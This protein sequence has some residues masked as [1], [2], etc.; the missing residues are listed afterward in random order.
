[1]SFLI[2]LLSNLLLSRELMIA[3]C[4]LNPLV[5]FIVFWMLQLLFLC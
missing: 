2:A 5:L 3:D 1:M 4:K